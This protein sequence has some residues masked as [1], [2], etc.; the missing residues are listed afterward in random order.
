MKTII[1]IFHQ[2]VEHTTPVH[3]LLKR[4]GFLVQESEVDTNVYFI[5]AGAVRVYVLDGDYEHTIR[6]GYQNN[7]IVALDSFIT[8]APTQFFIEAVRQTKV[9]QL[10]KEDVMTF[11]EQ[12]TAHLRLWTKLQNDLIL[13]Q[14]ERER[15]L[16]TQSPQERYERVLMRSPQLFQ[17]IPLKY[18]ASY[19]RMTPE[20]LSRIRATEN[21]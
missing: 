17:E 20:T 2:I 4:G 12:D 7:V 15:D 19:L 21:S 13:Q 1:E 16:L 6:F 11:F 9:V 8:G 14:L 5:E 3:H 18:I 10:A